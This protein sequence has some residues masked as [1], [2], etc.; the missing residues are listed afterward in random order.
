MRT[1]IFDFDGTLAD[2]F[3]IAADVF[4][5]LAAGRY[6]TDD[7]EIDVLRGLTAREA[8]RRVGVKWWQLPYI[9]FYARRQ[10]H[11]RQNEVEPIAGIAP[12]LRELRKRGFSLFIVSSNS[13]KNVEDFLQRNQLDDA[14]QGVAG[15]VGL[16]AKAKALRKIAEQQ[17]VMPA[18]CVYVGDEARDVDAAR[19]AGVPCIAVPWGYNTVAGLKRGHP[20]VIIKEPKELLSIFKAP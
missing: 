9:A 7:K 8:I 5:K 17:K 20:E 11:R 18:D 1:L 16:F 10:M 12:V 14:F 3:F 4:R 13:T 19:R 6:P 15:G 2:T